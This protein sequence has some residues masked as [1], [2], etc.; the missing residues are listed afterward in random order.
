LHT[1]SIPK[2]AGFETR[3]RKYLA[4]GTSSCFAGRARRHFLPVAK[5]RGLR[6]ARIGDE[7]SC[8]SLPALNGRAMPGSAGGWPVPKPRKHFMK[9]RPLRAPQRHRDT[10]LSTGKTAG[11][12]ERRVR[13]PAAIIPNIHKKAQRR[14]LRREPAG[15]P[16]QRPRL[17]QQA[18]P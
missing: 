16:S 1:D 13:P 17:T 5:A 18:S 9:G 3:R 11:G 14:T 12:V 4:L 7:T 10:L 15:T 8:L 6:A 2:G